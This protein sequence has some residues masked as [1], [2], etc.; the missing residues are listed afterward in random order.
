MKSSWFSFNNSPATIESFPPPIPS[1][2]RFF[3]GKA[4]GEIFIAEEG[5]LASFFGFILLR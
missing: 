2:E 3:R 5:N 1:R 4:S